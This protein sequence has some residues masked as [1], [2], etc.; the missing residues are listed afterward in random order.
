MDRTTLVTEQQ[1]DG[2][3]LL[4]T[5]VKGGFAI[6]AAAWI[7]T[8]DTGKWFL[9]IASP[10]VDEQGYFNAY[11]EVQATIRNFSNCAVGP[12]D[13]R[14]VGA[15]H[16]LVGDVQ[17]QFERFPVPRQIQFG[18]AELG[19]MS[20]EEAEIYPPISLSPINRKRRTRAT[21]SSSK[22]VVKSNL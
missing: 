22:R 14:L 4:E 7:K 15:T 9:Y 1:R 12:F 11:R 19:R 17:K 6:Q 5:L 21:S 2:Q 8:S 10:V 18:G 3:F 13:V 16:P 20:I